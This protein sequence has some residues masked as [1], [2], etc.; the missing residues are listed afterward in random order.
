MDK[1]YQTL[2]Q[3]MARP[4]GEPNRDRDLTYGAKYRSF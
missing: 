3:F 2:S 1:K 4:F